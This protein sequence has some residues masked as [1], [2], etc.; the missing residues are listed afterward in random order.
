MVLVVKNPA[1]NA[2]V[3][4]M[5]PGWIPA[6]GRSPGVRNGNPLQYSCLEDS[7]GRG[8]WWATVHGAEKRLSKH[9]HR[10]TAHSIKG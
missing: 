5:D 7:M 6:L 4:E 2:G 3:T 8:S 9:T 1:G 10:G